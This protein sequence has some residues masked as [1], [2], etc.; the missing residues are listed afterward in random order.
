MKIGIEVNT[1]TSLFKLDL[2]DLGCV[3]M[4]WT[5]VVQV[6]FQKKSYIS[7]TSNLQVLMILGCYFHIITQHQNIHFNTYYYYYYY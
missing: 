4:R 6:H 5:E 2:N 7:V 3:E 1:E